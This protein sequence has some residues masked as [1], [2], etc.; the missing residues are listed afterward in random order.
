MQ[1]K[2]VHMLKYQS[3]NLILVLCK[4]PFGVLEDCNMGWEFQRLWKK[5][6]ALKESYEKR[7]VTPVYFRI[8]LVSSLDKKHMTGRKQDSKECFINAIYRIDM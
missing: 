7:A 4:I 2:W 5:A 8:R 1:N 3:I 6:T